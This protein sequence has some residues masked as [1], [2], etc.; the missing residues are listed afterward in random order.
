MY[1]PGMGE[2]VD[3]HEAVF[4]FNMYN[5]GEREGKM[6][7]KSWE[8]MGRTSTYRMFNKKRSEVA[9]V[10]TFVNLEGV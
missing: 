5:L 10:K 2:V 3:R 4:K 6:S 8:Y 1:L 7:D 9:Q